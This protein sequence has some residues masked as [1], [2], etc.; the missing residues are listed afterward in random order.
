MEACAP[1]S[2][3]PRL[4]LQNGVSEGSLCCPVGPPGLPAPPHLWKWM[5]MS[6]LGV[7]GYAEAPGL[8]CVQ[9]LVAGLGCFGGWR[10]WR[11]RRVSPS[12][13]AWV[14][15]QGSFRPGCP[16]GA[17]QS[18]AYAR[19]AV[20]VHRAV[21][22]MG[23]RPPPAA[24]RSLGVP[25]RAKPVGRTPSRACTSLPPSLPPSRGACF[26]LAGHRLARRHLACAASAQCA[27]S[28]PTLAAWGAGG[29][30]GPRDQA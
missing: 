26:A 8:V 16:R 24:R 3:P 10:V 13:G 25:G 17:R 9:C 14:S 27:L 18:C 11:V 15:G 2:K 22:R 7:V 6:V 19:G 12:M 21:L 28:H 30:A 5:F 1:L 29:E 23:L 20:A 4:P